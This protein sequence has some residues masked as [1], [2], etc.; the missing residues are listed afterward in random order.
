MAG[1]LVYVFL[2]VLLGA[3]ILISQSGSGGEAS[4]GA[5]ECI[6]IEEAPISGPSGSLILESRRDGQSSFVLDLETGE[7]SE[8][9]DLTAHSTVGPSESGGLIYFDHVRASWILRS[10]QTGEE[11]ALDQLGLATPVAWLDDGRLL[12][13]GERLLALDLASGQTESA[14]SDAVFAQIEEQINWSSQLNWGR[15]S[16]YRIMP[17]PDLARLVYLANGEPGAQ[18]VMWDVQAHREAARLHWID[19]SNPP[20]WAPDSHSLAAGA[21]PFV[22]YEG[23]LFVN[24]VDADPYL[25]GVDL[26]QVGTDGQIRRLS[27]F[28]TGARA[29]VSRYRWSSSGA[30]LAAGLEFKTESDG[31]GHLAVLEPASGRVRMFCFPAG[32]GELTG[33]P[34]WSPDETMLALTLRGADLTP[35]VYVLDVGPASGQRVA[36]AAEA[37]GWWE[38]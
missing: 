37:V 7:K 15:Y 14:V 20:Q 33:F 8:L 27:A 13:G 21:P 30:R 31:S 9:P 3:G 5:A 6:Q 19:V 10:L 24:A 12:V 32:A 16:P 29:L 36:R 1:V 11:A 28:T 34:V 35:V 17:A 23:N 38:K 26:M 2:L 22:F 25:G 4:S 18:L